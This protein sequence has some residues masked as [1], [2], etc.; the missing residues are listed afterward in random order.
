MNVSPQLP[1]K[2]RTHL[3]FTEQRRVIHDL[4]SVCC[5]TWHDHNAKVTHDHLHLQEEKQTAMRNK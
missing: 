2:V 4:L 5:I 1:D 3:V